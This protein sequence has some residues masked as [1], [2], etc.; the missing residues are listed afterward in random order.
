MLKIF[1]KLEKSIVFIL[2]IMLYA[3]LLASFFLIMGIENWSLLNISRTSGVTLLMFVVVGIAMTMAYGTYDIG[4]RKSKPIISSL[5]LATAITDIITAL[6]ISIMNTNAANGFNFTMINI[7]L[8]AAAFI[9]QLIGIVLFVYGGNWIYFLINQP[10]KCCVVTSSENSFLELAEAVGHFKKQYRI[11]YVRDYRCADLRKVMIKCDT[12]FIYDVPIVERTE[13]IEFCYRHMI[14]IYFNPEIPDIVEINS[15][16]VIIDD[17]SLISAPVKELSFEQR[18]IKRLMDIVVSMAALII[19]SPLF[20]IC[21]L[22]IKICDGGKVIFKQQ[23]ATKD[24]KIFSVYKF[25]TMKEDAGVY[26]ATQDDD[27]IT[28]VGK[29]LRKYRLD[30]IPQMLNIL[31]GEMSLVGPRPEML[32]NIYMYTQEVP[33]FE[34]RLR[35]KAGL[36]GYAQ[37]AGKYNTTPKYKLILDLMYIEKYSV[38]KDI[39][40]I[41]QTLIVFFKPDSTEG[42]SGELQHKVETYAQRMNIDLNVKDNRDKND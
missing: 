36:T 17:I 29:I 3:W 27:R 20:L 15:K 35:V 16:N 2:K 28:P 24:G 37:I 5:A 14:N 8:L 42:F 12:V 19:L 9:V 25:R 22:A 1:K 23:R 26:S 6:Q 13:I 32:K 34:Y 33:E 11:D 4:Q 39:K 30:E 40:L 31:R 10:Q 38:M 21:A 18:V 7:G 41:L